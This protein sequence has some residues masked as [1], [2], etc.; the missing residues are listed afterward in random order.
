ML[1]AFLWACDGSTSPSPTA[2]DTTTTTVSATT[3]PSPGTTSTFPPVTGSGILRVGTTS[4]ISNLDPADAFTLG[5]WEILLTIGEGLLRFE[6]GDGSLVP[7]TARDLPEVSEDGL[8]YTFHLD[9]DAVFA[10]GT[11][12]TADVYIDQIERVLSLS[13]R[14]TNLISLYVATV[15]APDES[16]VV[17]DLNDAYAFFPTL[18]AGAPYLALHPDSYPQDQLNPA[19]E[20]PIYGTGPWYIDHYTETELVLKAN[21]RYPGAEQRPREIVIRVYGDP[22]TMAEALANGDLDLIWRGLDA[23]TAATLTGADGVTVNPVPGGT[24]HFLT[25]NHL[26][27]AVSDHRVRQALAE[28]IDRRAI[29]DG[30]LGEAF[31]PAFSP[32]PPGFLGSVAAFEDRYGEPDVAS[33]IDLLTAAGY[34]ET[35]PAEIELAYPPERFGLDIAAAM[36]EIELQIEAT[37]LAAVTLT[38]QP[39][40]TYVGSVVEGSYDLAFLGWL[41]DF[42][43]PH[44]YLAPFILEGGLGGTGQD[45]ATPEL[46][47]LVLEAAAQPS[48]EQRSATYEEIQKLFAE[49]VV[50]IPLWIEHQYIA[51]R[52]HVSGSE[53]F[54]NPESLNIG[55]MLQL[56]YR[57]IEMEDSENG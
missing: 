33:A 37:G 55:A 41:H 56:D 25:V 45:L 31:E 5:D 36:E 51:Y 28:L 3:V 9:P 4:P 2:P 39:W 10:D 19:P 16:T 21:P 6:P 35:S 11:P 17:F 29:I 57:A 46:A 22:E 15:E 34:T 54:P 30:V 53:A 12:L 20:A 23:T 14:G 40:N 43:D 49:D 52:D 48:A 24:L 7:G 38:S 47:D 27:P 18:V 1:L 44:N 32:I 26:G 42:P 8:T 13:G 50:T